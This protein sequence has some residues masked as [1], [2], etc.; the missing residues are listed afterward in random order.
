MNPKVPALPDLF[1][2][3]PPA[4]EQL[5]AAYLSRLSEQHR[6]E[7][8][9]QSCR[10]IRQYAARHNKSD[11][12][13]FTFPFEIDA[14]CRLHRFPQAWQQL[15]K[16]ERAAHGRTIRIRARSWTSEEL[17]WFRHYH[18]QILYF[19]GQY[20][21]ARH[22]FEAMLSD[23]ANRAER[24]VSY[25]LLWY[26]YSPARRVRQRT[27]VTLYHIYKKL[28]RDLRDWSHWRTF[29]SG[30]SSEVL[31][32]A[33]VARE[34]LLRN[35]S[36]LRRVFARIR[37][38]QERRLDASVSSGQSDL[39]RSRKKVRQYQHKVLRSQAS[40]FSDVSK[41]ERRLEKIFPQLK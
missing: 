19:L 30:I 34:D 15:K 2:V 37:E 41:E 8:V 29:V 32:L 38:E 9:E 23:L 27:D 39:T 33:G 21:R 12:A 3:A 14:L 16:L 22:L 1:E 10:R 11:S 17:V 24:D 13:G 4:A 20:E 31:A 28:H 5:Y 35:P 40:K 6:Y 7:L 25:Q 26:V 36:L 18:P